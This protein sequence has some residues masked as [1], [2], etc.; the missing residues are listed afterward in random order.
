MDI[1]FCCVLCEKVRECTNFM[2]RMIDDKNLS[3]WKC[4][5][6]ALLLNLSNWS[7]FTAEVVRTTVGG[8]RKTGETSSIWS[9]NP[10][11]APLYSLLCGL[12]LYRTCFCFLI[13]PS[14]RFWSESDE[15]CP[16]EGFSWFSFLQNSCSENIFKCVK[17]VFKTSL[18][19][20][21]FAIDGY[22]VIRS[23]PV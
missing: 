3:G 15:C 16:E 1:G 5:F 9:G 11:P 6:K 23:V 10:D 2:Q 22:V 14:T 12:L 8:M 7:D 21:C 13:A 4:I 19:K 18:L 20:P 17:T